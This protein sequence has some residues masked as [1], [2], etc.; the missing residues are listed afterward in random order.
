MNM[1]P[2]EA[3]VIGMAVVVGTSLGF[4]VSFEKAGCTPT[5]NT[6]IILS[7]GPHPYGS[8]GP[9]SGILGPNHYDINGIWDLRPYCLGPRTF[10]VSQAQTDPKINCVG[11]SL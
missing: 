9:N 4:Q 3:Y 10:K 5:A 11:P 8:K 1:E 6:Y 2:L 7:H